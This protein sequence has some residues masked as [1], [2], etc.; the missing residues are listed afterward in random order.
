MLKGPINR[1]RFIGNIE[2]VSYLVLLFLA[3]PLK[4]FANM[5]MMVTWVG[6]IHGFL[7][8]LYCFSILEVKLS[9]SWNMGTSLIPFIAALVPFGPFL[10]DNWLKKIAH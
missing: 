5:P 10:I 3:M 4:Y 6:W 7:F 9:M 1:L 8:V 2:G